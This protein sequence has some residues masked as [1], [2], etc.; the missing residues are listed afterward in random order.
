[1][2]GGGGGTFI[3][4]WLQR[5]IHTRT[6]THTHAHTGVCSTTCMITFVS[7]YTHIGMGVH[8][9][10]ILGTLE[11]FCKYTPYKGG[12]TTQNKYCGKSGG[13]TN[14]RRSP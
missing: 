1:M 8:Y 5:M 10:C 2:R 13:G 3:V 14:T 12:S 11:L 9:P 6:Y 4:M 7:A